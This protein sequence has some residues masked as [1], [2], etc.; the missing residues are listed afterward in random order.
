MTTGTGDQGPGHEDE[1]DRRLRELTEEVASAARIKEPSAA[2]RAKRAEQDRKTGQRNQ[3]QRRRKRGGVWLAVVVVIVAVA[4]AVA[5]LRLSHSPA[6]PPAGH[7][8]LAGTSSPALPPAAGTPPADPFLGTPAADWAD[9][10]SGIVVPAAEP[11]GS[12]TAAQVA[13]AYQTTRRLLIAANL[14]TPTLLGGAPT[15][16]ADLLTTQQRADFLS[17]LNKKGVNHGGYPLSTRKWVASFFPG[18]AELIGNVIKVHGVMSAKTV[19][20]SGTTVLP[21]NARPR[22]PSPGLPSTRTRYPQRHPAAAPYAGGPRVL[23]RPAAPPHHHPVDL[24]IG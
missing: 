17:A 8:S 16:F 20:E 18:S 13:S 15:A 23:N 7:P 19:H 14:N 22:L 21:A 1:L 4:G 12:F 24:N 11:A 3:R 10:E 5:W 2:E 9:G 6:R